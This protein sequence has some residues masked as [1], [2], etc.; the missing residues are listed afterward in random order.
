MLL[1]VG[2]QVLFPELMQRAGMRL[3][4]FV[5]GLLGNTVA[6]VMLTSGMVASPITSSCPP[7]VAC[8]MLQAH[9]PRPLWH[10][11]RRPCALCV[12]LCIPSSPPASTT[13]PIVFLM[14][15][16]KCFWAPALDVGQQVWPDIISKGDASQ[17]EKQYLLQLAG[18]S[19][20]VR[21]WET[22]NPVPN[23][24]VGGV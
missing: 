8:S 5:S 20:S 9:C 10:A 11:S 14:V 3:V 22:P 13:M 23:V 12:A 21:C 24:C 7:F 4:V 15:W 17:L 19:S 16:M 6:I 1:S 2:L 18:M